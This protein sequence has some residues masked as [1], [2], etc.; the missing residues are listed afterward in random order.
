MVTCMYVNLISRKNYMK[1]NQKILGIFLRVN[2]LLWTLTSNQIIFLYFFLLLCFAILSSSIIFVFLR[3]CYKNTKHKSEE[4]INDCRETVD[5][6]LYPSVIF[7]YI[8]SCRWNLDV[9][10]EVDVYLPRIVSSIP[11]PVSNKGFSSPSGSSG[12]WQL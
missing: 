2:G 11:T 9:L 8:P 5:C 4:A 1:K 10:T 12:G 3:L 7:H 6:R